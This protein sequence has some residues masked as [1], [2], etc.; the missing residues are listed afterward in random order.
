ME[1]DYQSALIWLTDAYQLLSF[2]KGKADNLLQKITATIIKT[3]LILSRSKITENIIEG[4]VNQEGAIA[5]TES[6]LIAYK[7]GK[8]IET[9]L[10][11]QGL[12]DIHLCK[13]DSIATILHKDSVKIIDYND[14]A[15]NFEHSIKLSEIGETKYIYS[16]TLK[17]GFLLNNRRTYRIKPSN[18]QTLE[19]LPE[20]TEIFMGHSGHFIIAFSQDASSLILVDLRSNEPEQQTID[21]PELKNQKV[22]H[23]NY[24]DAIKTATLKLEDT[25]TKKQ[26]LV[27]IDVSSARITLEV[28]LPKKYYIKDHATTEG[29]FYYTLDNKGTFSIYNLIDNKEYHRTHGSGRY[30]DFCVS[31]DGIYTC[32]IDSEGLLSILNNITGQLDFNRIRCLKNPSSLSFTND[33]S[34]LIVAD[35]KNGDFAKLQFPKF[36]NNED[37]WFPE[38]YYGITVPIDIESESET[39]RM[40]IKFPTLRA[41]K[42]G[43]TANGI[44]LSEIV[45]SHKNGSVINPK[46]ISAQGNYPL[47]EGPEN[48]FDGDVFTK[49]FNFDRNSTITFDLEDAGNISSMTFFSANDS[50]PRDPIE[51]EISRLKS[52]KEAT[53]ATKG[54]IIQHEYAELKLAIESW[55]KETTKSSSDLYSAIK[56]IFAIQIDSDGRVTSYT[57][58]EE[59]SNSRTENN[60]W[61]LFGDQSASKAWHA[62]CSSLN[63]TINSHLLNGDHILQLAKLEPSNKAVKQK[64]G[65]QMIFEGDKVNAYDTLKPLSEESIENLVNY[66]CALLKFKDFGELQKVINTT[67]T[68]DRYGKNIFWDSSINLLSLLADIDL[69]DEAINAL[70][71]SLKGPI[72]SDR[73]ISVGSFYEGNSSLL[74]IENS[75][76]SFEAWIKLSQ[77]KPIGFILNK[78]GGGVSGSDGFSI[79]QN[80]FDSIR[81][82]TRSTPRNE[83]EQI[84]VTINSSDWFHYAVTWHKST[85][86]LVVYINGEEALKTYAI[87]GPIEEN[88]IKVTFG[89]SANSKGND[90]FSN[91]SG[92]ITEVRFWKYSLPHQT[93]KKRYNSR[94]SGNEYGLAQYWPMNQLPDAHVVSYNIEIGSDGPSQI[95]G[96][97]N[98]YKFRAPGTSTTY[99]GLQASLGFLLK[100]LNK[101]QTKDNLIETLNKLNSNTNDRRTFLI[102]SLIAFETGDAVTAKQLFQ[103][104]E[105]L[106]T[107]NTGLP[108]HGWRHSII[109]NHLAD[110]CR[111]LGLN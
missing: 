76:F 73:S 39:E 81:F 92:S 38:R 52:N 110:R 67:L 19:S 103:K 41:D 57:P 75:S 109:D 55:I 42:T 102:C 90:S 10:S 51:F 65:I 33:G 47:G 71:E 32:L 106:N 44:Q 48:L 1:K 87:T 85:N 30:R 101:S 28:Q 66:M 99:G 77:E 68:S 24:A 88:P 18:I 8:K 108:E 6:A 34:S 26:K 53:L 25:E 46:N 93:I 94:L 43:T 80:S 98:Y 61:K 105:Q 16:S 54:A 82:E 40:V 59:Q 50:P 7:D 2:D 14:D 56:Q 12:I 84:D 29:S 79:W 70:P 9:A 21:L 22:L 69:S 107:I 15:T 13:E 35:F 45:I 27:K 74:G 78:G 36:T 97:K 64:Y 100:S 83:R 62:R 89:T 60:L 31:N 5:L 63:S 20:L 86:E 72:S 4:K 11:A 49:Y 95:K 37:K 111:N 3:P 23:A 17:Q 58:V 96:N 104:A 91:W